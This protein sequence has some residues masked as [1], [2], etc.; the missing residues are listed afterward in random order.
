MK[1]RRHKLVAEERT[2]KLQH[3]K[4]ELEERKMLQHRKREPEEHKKPVQHRKLERLRRPELGQ[5]RLQQVGAPREWVAG[6]RTGRS[7]QADHDGAMGRT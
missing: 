4:Q 2:M 6:C 7:R 1:L 3:H 5:S